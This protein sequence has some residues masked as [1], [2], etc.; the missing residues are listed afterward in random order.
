MGYVCVLNLYTFLSWTSPAFNRLRGRR[1]RLIRVAVFF[2][3]LRL[4]LFLFPHSFFVVDHYKPTHDLYRRRESSSCNGL[5]S[6]LYIYVVY[7]APVANTAVPNASAA[8][9][10]VH[11]RLPSPRPSCSDSMIHCF[12]PAN[13]SNHCRNDLKTGS[14]IRLDNF[15]VARVAHMYKIT[16][17]QFVIRFLPSTRISEVETDAP[18]IKFDRFMVRR[19]HY[20]KTAIF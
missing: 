17:H 14:I 4:R 7:G 20:K 9:A 8:N 12:I 1:L 18:I 6:L 11:F 15:E 10:A 13:R 2:G 3:I 5:S 16:E 19:Y